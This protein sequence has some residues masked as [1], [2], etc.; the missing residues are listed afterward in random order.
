MK[1]LS[2]SLFHILSIVLLSGILATHATPAA[3]VSG[4]SLLL[5]P[6]FFADTPVD[7]YQQKIA[8]ELFLDAARDEL[9]RKGYELTLAAERVTFESASKR[10]QGLL[11][12][13]DALMVIRIDH[14]LD[15]GFGQGTRSASYL[16]VYASARLLAAGSGELLWEGEGQGTSN[17]S[18][19]GITSTRLDI[20]QTADE[21]MQDMFSTLPAAG[22]LSL[23]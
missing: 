11:G 8:A 6:I 10:A 20:A 2:K 13:E 23:R 9:R 18:V 5:P 12:D 7:R 19:T 16:E 14:Y 21:L 4:E 3:A 1:Q 17:R 15:A 22:Q